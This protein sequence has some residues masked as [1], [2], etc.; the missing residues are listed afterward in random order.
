M[1]DIVLIEIEKLSKN[2]KLISSENE[3]K[4]ENTLTIGC[5]SKIFSGVYLYKVLSKGC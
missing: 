1:R 4:K 3:T 5:F 2:F